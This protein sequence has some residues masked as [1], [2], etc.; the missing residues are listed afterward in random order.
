MKHRRVKNKF[1]KEKSRP[2]VIPLD[3]REK[4][5]MK[6]HQTILERVIAHPINWFAGLLATILALCY[7]ILD[8]LHEPEIYHPTAQIDDPFFVRFSLHN[9]SSI[10]PMTN[11]RIKCVLLR[12]QLENNM[13]LVG[14]PIDDGTVSDIQPGQTVEYA[15]PIHKAIDDIGQIVQTTI[16]IESTFKTLGYERITDSELFNW[17]MIS[18]QWIKGEIIN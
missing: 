4:T 10:F 2:R 6:P 16:Q 3:I 14:I 7:P 17:N 15:C 12:V 11:M 9:P 5:L 13:S 1:P 8:A 18:R